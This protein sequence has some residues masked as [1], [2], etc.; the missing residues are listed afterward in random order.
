MMV[1]STPGVNF[2]NIL[3]TAFMGAE[4]KSEKKTDNLTVFLVL[5]GHVPI[6]AAPKMLMKSTS[7]QYL[8]L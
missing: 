4:T 5:L 7:S 6:K 2:I 8:G 3:W 1:K